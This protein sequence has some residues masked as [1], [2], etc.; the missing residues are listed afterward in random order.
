[1]QSSSSLLG[2]LRDRA[3]GREFELYNTWQRGR[4]RSQPAEQMRKSKS[5]VK[6]GQVSL[7]FI[8]FFSLASCSTSEAAGIHIM[9][10]EAVETRQRYVHCTSNNEPCA[11]SGDLQPWR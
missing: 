6:Q 3:G 2:E 8:F 1:M 4:K 11:E 5:R 10:A 7:L 9:D